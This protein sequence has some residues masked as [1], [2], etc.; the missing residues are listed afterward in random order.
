MYLII[1]KFLNQRFV[2]LMS[3]ITVANLKMAQDQSIILSERILPM[4]TERLDKGIK[5]LR[6]KLNAPGNLIAY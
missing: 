4:F 2:N 5:D 6:K 3:E 1:L